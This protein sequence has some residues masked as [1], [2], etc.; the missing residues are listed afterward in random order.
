MSET[1]QALVLRRRDLGENDVSL[2]L[3]TRE[4]GRVDAVAK[5]ARKAGSR[6][7]SA[8]QPL[9]LAEIELATGKKTAYIT[10]AQPQS[11]FR[12]L[13]N[14]YDRLVHALSWAELV[15]GISTH[16]LIHEELFDL[17]LEGLQHLETH[18]QPTVALLWSEVSL[19]RAEGLLP[20]FENCLVCGT[21]IRED[22]A[23]MSATHGGYLCPAHESE[24]P[25][26][27]LV[28]GRSLKA[29]A[30]L[31]EFAEPPPQMKGAIDALALLTHFW[32]NHFSSPL[33]A[34][35]SLL[36]MLYADETPTQ[37][38]QTNT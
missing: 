17:T 20:S 2:V 13:R 38:V 16:D 10:Q 24:D 15:A 37:G 9:Q 23:W 12:G 14:D 27:I 18:T 26:R 1:L 21:I 5:G 30:R 25:Y 11:A 22:P 3:L 8:S 33:R 31:A 7:L 19:L 29:L 4:R 28:G 32:A 34:R 6:L 36:Q 35:D